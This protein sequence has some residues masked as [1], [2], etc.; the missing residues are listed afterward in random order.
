MQ[1][2]TAERRVVAEGGGRAHGFELT[3]MS[4]QDKKKKKFHPSE[5]KVCLR[6]ITGN[7]LMGKGH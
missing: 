4:W 1:L 5:T 6:V 3:E 7:W 2:G